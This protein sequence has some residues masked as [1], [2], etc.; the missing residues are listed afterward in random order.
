MTRASAIA[1]EL[2][3]H[4]GTRPLP[5]F[6]PEEVTTW[7]IRRFLEATTDETPLWHDEE[8]ALRS[9]WDGLCSSIAGRM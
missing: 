3:K 2:R 4:V 5:D 9:G 8:Y 1:E 7:G 6:P